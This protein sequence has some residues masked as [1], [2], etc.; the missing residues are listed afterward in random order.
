V[1]LNLE[2]L[3]SD[4]RD[5]KSRVLC[6]LKKI[7]LCGIEL[8]RYSFERARQGS[9]DRSFFRQP[10]APSGTGI[11]QPHEMPASLADHG[12]ENERRNLFNNGPICAD[13]LQ[14]RV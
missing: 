12:V 10:N 7:K 3:Y 4:I 1:P 14:A 11:L 2:R 13:G 8:L 5:L 6:D 9:A